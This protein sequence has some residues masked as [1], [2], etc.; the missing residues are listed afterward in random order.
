M[1]CFVSSKNISDDA[2]S[3]SQLPCRLC[4]VCIYNIYSLHNWPTFCLESCLPG[5]YL[6]RDTG[7]DRGSV[8]KKPHHLPLYPVYGPA[9]ARR[10]LVT[11]A[12]LSRR[13][14]Q[15][16]GALTAPHR[17]QLLP[18]RHPSYRDTLTHTGDCLH[19]FGS[20]KVR[21]NISEAG[22]AIMSGRDY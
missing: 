17:G 16:S 1:P 10:W 9:C 13:G 14:S 18:R 5:P 3:S 2:V 20:C 12:R 8:K 22:I 6:Q 4:L 19:S 7:G 11:R 15:P 21:D